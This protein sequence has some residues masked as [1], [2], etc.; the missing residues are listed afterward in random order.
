MQL[1]N[2]LLASFLLL[3][4]STL[5]Y[6][7]CFYEQDEVKDFAVRS[8]SI[9]R[10]DTGGK[11]RLSPL[12]NDPLQKFSQFL[13]QTDPFLTHFLTCSQLAIFL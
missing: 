11:A 13:S 9:S 1:E 7:T 10:G 4:S 8:E 5:N 3:L 2:V 12:T 6:A